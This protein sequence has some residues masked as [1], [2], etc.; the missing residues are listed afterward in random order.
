MTKRIFSGI[1]ILTSVGALGIIIAGAL[2]D[3]D[4]LI[5]R[6]L[7]AV[8]VAAL[9]LYVVSDLRLQANEPEFQTRIDLTESLVAEQSL[10]V[11][12]ETQV[13]MEVPLDST[14]A[15]MATIGGSVKN[16]EKVSAGQRTGSG[17]NYD[18]SDLE[19]SSYS[20]VDSERFNEEVDLDELEDFASES[21]LVDLA[22]YLEKDSD[23][24]KIGNI[25]D[26]V[27]SDVDDDYGWPISGEWPVVSDSSFNSKTHEILD[28]GINPTG[29]ATESIE[30]IEDDLTVQNK[31]LLDLNGDDLVDLVNNQ[32]ILESTEVDLTQEI[33]LSDNVTESETV[34]TIESEIVVQ[35]PE[36]PSQV[37]IKPVEPTQSLAEVDTTQKVEQES[38]DSVAFSGAVDLRQAQAVEFTSGIDEAIKAG[39]QKVIE[40]LIEQGMLTTEGEISDRDVRTMVYVAFTSHELRKLI[41]AGGTPS[42]DNKDIDLGPVELFDES[43]HSPAPKT[44]YKAANPVLDT[45]TPEIETNTDQ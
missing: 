28:S 38:D 2:A 3:G 44:I 37:A 17:A 33:D 9:G 24:S 39:E 36:E 6:F 15:Y 14:A 27:E 29:P 1:F 21:N 30:I 18:F 25:F 22:E 26:L 34:Q 42:E 10:M 20:K 11:D 5:V 32:E 40:T 31:E 19:D 41:K 16:R 35:V 7:T 4:Q 23:D 45:A 12:D 43:I 8:V 13:A